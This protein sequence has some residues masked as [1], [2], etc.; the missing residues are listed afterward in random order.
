MVAM[1]PTRTSCSTTWHSST[2]TRASTPRQSPSTCAPSLS[3]KR[4]SAM[5]TPRQG[6][7]SATWHS[8]TLTK[9]RTP[10][11]SPATCAPWLLEKRCLAPTIPVR[12]KFERTIPIY[13]RKW[14]R[15]QKWWIKKSEGGSK[16]IT[17][18][19]LFQS[20]PPF[21]Q[22]RSHLVLDSPIGSHLT[23][24]NGPTLQHKN[25]VLKL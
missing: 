8:S 6:T 7:R 11:P 15:K 17:C 10:R 21:H 24:K 16:N 2:G 25:S 20:H 23:V 4:C 13:C 12:K 19:G 5:N 14:G 22:L 3:E 9:A 1:S 18:T